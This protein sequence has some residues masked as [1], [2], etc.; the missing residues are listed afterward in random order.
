MD[1]LCNGI[2]GGSIGIVCVNTA[3]VST[4]LRQQGFRQ[5]IEAAGG[6]TILEPEYRDGDA[7]ASQEAAQGFIVGHDDLVGLF[8]T[9]EGSSVG[10]GNAI[11]ASGEDIVGIGF[12]K[13]DANLELLEDGSLDAVMAQ[14]PFTM[15]YIGIAQ[16]YAALNGLST[17]PAVIDT[18]VAVLRK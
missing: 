7:A 4:I 2:T 18:G 16:A 17:G 14:N 10:V 13:S 9:N 11:K 6:F 5:A 1:R 12:D 3:T 15:G 8:G